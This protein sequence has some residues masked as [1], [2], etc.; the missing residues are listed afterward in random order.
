MVYDMVLAYDHKPIKNDINGFPPNTAGWPL[1]PVEYILTKEAPLKIPEERILANI[2]W[3]PDES[4]VVF[5]SNIE[6]TN[7]YFLVDIDIS[8]GVDA[9]LIKRKKLDVM[10]L[11]KVNELIETMNTFADKNGL[12]RPKID[13]DYKILPVEKIEVIE[14]NSIRLDFFSSPVPVFSKPM[15]LTLDGMEKVYP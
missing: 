7:E 1:Y 15:T 9:P 6:D 4:G 10:A 5:V 2:A 3:K 13:R 8:Q 12:S 14:K 11:G